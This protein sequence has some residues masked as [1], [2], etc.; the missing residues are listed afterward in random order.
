M[1][2][3]GIYSRGD[4]IVHSHYGVGEIVDITEKILGEKGIKDKIPSL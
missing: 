1:T 2:Q 4:Q 3:D